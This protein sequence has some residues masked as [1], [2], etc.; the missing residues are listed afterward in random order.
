MMPMTMENTTAIMMEGTLMAT[1]ADVTRDMIAARPIPAPTPTMPPRLVGAAASV[2]ELPQNAAL[3]RADGFFQ[4][5]LSRTF[6]DGN[7]PE[8][9]HNADTADEQGDA[10]NPDELRICGAAE[11][12]ASPAP[13]LKDPVP[14]T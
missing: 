11:I 4:T 6:R 5:D 10:R 1:G 3:V 13:A 7:R 12:T 8:R 9:R 14:D 2:R